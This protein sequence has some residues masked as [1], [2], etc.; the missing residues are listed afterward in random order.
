MDKLKRKVSVTQSCLT[1][2]DPVDCSTRLLCPW[3]SPGKNAGV[4]SHSLLQRN[5][6]N[7]GLNLGLPHCRQILYC[8]SHQGRPLYITGRNIKD[9]IMLEN[10]LAILQKVHHRIVM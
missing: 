7:Q 6:P 1:L 4:G 8:L 10:C 3:D 5:L 9:T 2:C